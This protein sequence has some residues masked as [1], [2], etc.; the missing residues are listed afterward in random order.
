MRVPFILLALLMFATTLHA[1]DSIG[2]FNDDAID[3]YI[4]KTIEIS[5]NKVT[6]R[7]IILRELT[8][9]EGDTI[10]R[11]SLKEE[12]ATSTNNVTNTSLFNYVKIENVTHSN[13]EVTVN[14]HIE[15][16]WY[17]WPAPIFEI[18]ERNFNVWWET[19]RL[20][21]TNYGLYVVK[22]NFRG[23][24][25][26]L[27]IRLQ[28]GFEQNIV[29]DYS[30]PYITKKQNSGLAFGGSFRQ[31]YQVNYATENN[32][33]VKNEKADG[34]ARTR[35]SPYLQYFYR[36]G[37]YK[38]HRVGLIYENINISKDIVE[39]NPNYLMTDQSFLQFLQLSYYFK[40]DR[41]NNKAYP[42]TGYYFDFKATQNGTGIFK[43]D[44]N[45]L[46]LTTT[47]KKYHH[48]GKRMYV[49]G[50]ISL[51]A[52]NNTE[53]PYYLNNGLGYRNSIRA[54]E[55]SVIDGQNI[56]LF[57]FNLKYNIIKPTVYEINWIKKFNKFKSIP[58]ALYF[59]VFTD[60]GTAHNRF[61]DITNLL[62]NTFLLGGGIGLDYVTYYDKIFRIEFSTNKSGL[63]RVYLN[64]IAPI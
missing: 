34:F 58:Y 31:N 19:R 33:L 25:E 4:I 2:G 27:K 46:F 43:N 32:A 16:R 30:I 63:S 6:K 54:Y 41:R 36:H 44:L 23:R 17:L 49:A 51:K 64:F 35:F 39:L 8:F 7:P 12:F 50:S 26:K 15:E 45:V 52:S 9:Q 53:Q 1:Q 14:I 62:D 21:R 60:G 47:V 11:T 40:L 3:Y 29:L 28:L 20:D 61:S 55:L 56:A 37:L 24:K 59:N 10:I 57:K 13:S 48:F 18:A 42:L 22:E 5:G 38:T